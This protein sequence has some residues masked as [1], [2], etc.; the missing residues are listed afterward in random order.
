MYVTTLILLP[1]ANKG[2]DTSLDDRIPNPQEPHPP[3]T[4]MFPI[5]HLMYE[6]V[7]TTG[8]NVILCRMDNNMLSAVTIAEVI[9][10]LNESSML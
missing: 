6:V 8:G 10:Y 4:D 7:R 9:A 2:L 3:P 5:D 1:S